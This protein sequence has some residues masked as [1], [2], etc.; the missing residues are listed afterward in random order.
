MRFHHVLA[1]LLLPAFAAAQRTYFVD[2]VNGKDTN[3][4]TSRA[5][6][7][8]SLTKAS[9]LLGDGD[10]L[11]I[12]PG[13]YSPS[14]TGETLPVKFGDS[15][16]R[17][18]QNKIR[19]VTEGGPAVTIFDGENG[20]T[21]AGRPM[22]RFYWNADGA[23]LSGLTFTNTGASSY[24]SMA[25]RLGSTSGGLFAARNVEIHGCVFRN[26]HRAVVLFGTSPNSSPPNPTKGIE[27]HDNLIVNTTGR[28]IAVWAEDKSNAIYNNTIVAPRNDG[29]WVDRLF[30][31]TNR[32]SI[33]NNIVHG[34]AGNGIAVGANGKTATF[35]GNNA[36]KNKTNYT[37]MTFGASNT[38][39]DPMFVD[40]AKGDYHLKAGSPMVQKGV[41]TVPVARHDLDRFPRAH[42]SDGDGFAGIDK[43]CYQYTAYGMTMAGAWKPGGKVTFT[44]TS[45]APGISVVLFA[46]GAGA[47]T[48]H[49]F[50]TLLVDLKTTSPEVLSGQA[51]GSIPL[52]IPND[53]NFLGARLVMQGGY[54][55]ARIHALNVVDR[56]F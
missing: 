25:I 8:K 37:G 34:G 51:P 55:G 11:V 19:I 50:G 9:T 27:F 54:V 48:L 23:S 49:P 42:D 3:P 21:S 17:T 18:T 47:T 28:A 56:T 22:M 40:E 35:A 12:L 39:L 44:F 6:A 43:G 33:L 53:P 16:K 15:G 26:V 24:W 36:F 46:A 20:A 1:L 4:G 31:R 14:K 10:T 41:F 52:A 32:S 2:A 45:K 5:N 38:S 30:G 7:V 29:I 13:T